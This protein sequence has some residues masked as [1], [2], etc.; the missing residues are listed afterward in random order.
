MVTREVADEALDRLDFRIGV[1][2]DAADAGPP[3][4]CAESGCTASNRGWGKSRTGRP[5][6]RRWRARAPPS[7][8]RSRRRRCPAPPGF[9]PRR[10][11][12]PAPAASPERGWAARAWSCRTFSTDMRIDVRWPWP[13]PARGRDGPTSSARGCWPFPPGR[14]SGRL[15]CAALRKVFRCM[16]G[17]QEATTTRVQFLRRDLLADHRLAGVRA[18]VLVVHR[19]A[20]AGK[21][22]PRCSRLP[23]RQ[24]CARCSRRTSRRRPRSSTY[25]LLSPLALGRLG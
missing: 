6:C 2:L 7:P 20:H 23:P 19:A 16:C 4:P 18:H 9:P 11:R 10:R 17:E 15:V 14:D 13:W 25:V 24:P 3:P 12:S 5:S 8:L 21:F 1:E 22:W